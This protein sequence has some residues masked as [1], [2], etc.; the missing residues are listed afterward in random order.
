MKPVTLFVI[1][2]SVVSLAACTPSVPSENGSSSSSE[3]SE[4]TVSL[5][6]YTQD[7][8]S[9]ASGD[10]TFRVDRMVPSTDITPDEILTLL[11][12]GPMEDEQ[13]AGARTY[14]GLTAVGDSFLGV[15]VQD[16]VAIVNFKPEAYVYLNGAAAMQGMVKAPIEKTLKA[17][18]MI[19]D[20]QYAQDGVLFTEWDA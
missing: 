10:P 15:T 6:F 20:V 4:A 7:G 3:S 2:L 8:L 13:T 19:T 9:N 1:G 17:F 18:L 5:Y 16:N 12:D 11:F 14:E